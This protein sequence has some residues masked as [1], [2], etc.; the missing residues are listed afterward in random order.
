MATTHKIELTGMD[1]LQRL[2]V[3]GGAAAVRATGKALYWEAN[4][5][6]NAS[7]ELVPVAT[8]DLKSSGRV[9]TPQTDGASVYVD[10]IYGTPY[11]LAVHENL[12]SNHAAPTQAKYLEI[13]VVQQ[14]T[15]MG[16]RIADQVEMT[17]RSYS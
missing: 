5:A 8:G 6:F 14:A 3:L 15:G 10:I 16:R 17:L 7:Q 1:K 9:D 2:L 12:E 4:E 13:P 11:A